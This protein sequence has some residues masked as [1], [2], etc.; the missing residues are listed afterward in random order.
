METPQVS[1]HV[2]LAAELRKIYDSEINIEIS[3]LWDGGID[4]H[5]GDRMNGYLA[6]ENVPS[7]ADVIPWFQE[8]I[9]HFLPRLHV[10]AGPGPGG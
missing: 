2:D 6:E 4:L 7:M 8:A 3:W 10:D 9:A 5:L 1:S